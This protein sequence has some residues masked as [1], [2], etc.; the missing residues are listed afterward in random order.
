MLSMFVGTKVRKIG[1]ICKKRAN[2]L[3]KG[4]IMMNKAVKGVWRERKA[5]IIKNK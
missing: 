3:V 2:N 4:G 1:E 5:C